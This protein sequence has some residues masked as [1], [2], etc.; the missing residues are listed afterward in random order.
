MMPLDTPS[1]EPPESLDAIRRRLAWRHAPIAAALIGVVLCLPSLRT[2]FL[3]DDYY[4]RALLTGSARF[5]AYFGGSMD[6]F[7]FL[8]GDD[9]RTRWAMSCGVVPWWTYPHIKAAFWRPL[10]VATHCL[11]YLLWPDSPMLM[12]AQNI[13]WYGALVFAVGVL[14]RRI[15]TVAW[16]AGLAALMYA[17]D[18]AH[19]TPVGFIA[20]RNAVMAA[21][22]G[23]LA[24]IA[25]DRWRRERWRWGGVL[26]VLAL[27]VSLL[28]AEAGLATCAYLFAY[29]VCLSNGTWRQK[30]ASL[31]VYIP[32]VVLWRWIWT[33]A[34]SGC[35][36]MGLYIDP[37][38]EPLRFFGGVA[39]RAPILLLAQ[40]AAPASDLT[41]MIAPR[42]Q[43]LHGIIA[44]CFVAALVII[45][46]RVLRRDRAARFWAIGMVLSLLPVCATMPMDRLLVFIGVGAMGL[47]AQLVALAF[48]TKS[49]QPSPAA[50]S[51]WFRRGVAWPLIAFHL[52]LAPLL[53][54]F[55]ASLPMGP[56]MILS[57]FE[58][59]AELDVSV[60]NQDLILVN[61][62]SA[63]HAGYLSIFADLSGRPVPRRV[64]ILAPGLRGIQVKR[65]DEH[66]LAIRPTGS[67]LAWPFD[68]LFRGEQFPLAVGDQVDLPGMTATVMQATDHGDPTEVTFRFE[69][70][71]EDTSLRWLQ[72]T[73]G[74][75][76]PFTPPPVG[77]TV[78]L[79]AGFTTPFGVVM[80]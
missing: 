6:M 79:R 55:R 5:E 40:W 63:L 70:P 13:F 58:V 72:W 17:I 52:I 44:V 69:V 19:G 3:L 4:H 30:V 80:L 15:M 10:A 61:P 77:E 45:F 53:L 23:M 26:A 21:F 18:D 76:E 37:A 32:V 48:P 9:A 34:G 27:L 24:V 42:Y 20:N 41:I 56:E 65:V 16:V 2:G 50:S 46:A 35:V 7:R 31:A 25:H 67:F 71:L 57:Q 1:Q 78:E 75:F 12:H 51:G 43:R 29:E 33:L 49:V 28:C 36:G 38:T 47:A 11:D 73:T 14:Y 62:P 74:G 59:R 64:R 39:S 8:D 22:F 68:R 60:E 66:T 54:P